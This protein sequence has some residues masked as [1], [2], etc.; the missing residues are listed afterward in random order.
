MDISL[1]KTPQI[2]SPLTEETFCTIDELVIKLLLVK[3]HVKSVVSWLDHSRVLS[4]FWDKDPLYLGKASLPTKLPFIF[5]CYTK[6]WSKKVSLVKS[7]LGGHSQLIHRLHPYFWTKTPCISEKHPF[8]PNYHS[9]STST[10][11]AGLKKLV[12]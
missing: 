2:H 8:P 3:S 10:P 4:P 5:D 9:Y 11:K 12:W 1:F 7:T 6:S